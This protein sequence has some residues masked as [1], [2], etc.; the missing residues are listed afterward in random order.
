MLPSVMRPYE[1]RFV[2]LVET[3]FLSLSKLKFWCKKPFKAFLF[4]QLDNGKI[5]VREHGG[6]AGNSAALANNGR[7]VKV[8]LCD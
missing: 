3:F 8:Q 2:F 4:L 6:G 7:Y 1:E 5:K